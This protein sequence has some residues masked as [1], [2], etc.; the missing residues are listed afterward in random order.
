VYARSLG[1]NFVEYNIETDRDKKEEMKRKSGGS[2]GVPLLDIEG[3]IVRGFSPE[4][5][6]AAID[7]SLARR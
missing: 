7:N 1:V 3:Q 5:M 6:K 4:A 2:T